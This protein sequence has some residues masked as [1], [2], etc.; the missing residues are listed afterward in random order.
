[1]PA[2]R[3]RT[4]RTSRWRRPRTRAARS[5]RRRCKAGAAERILDVPVGTA[6]G[7]YT[8]RA[9]FLGSA[10][11]VDTRKVKISGTFNPSIGVDDA[12]RVK[13]VALT[14]GDETVVILKVDA[15]FVVRGHAVRSRAAAR[16]RVRGQGDPRGVAQRTRRGRSSPAHGPLKLGSG[17]DAPDRLRPLP[18]RRSRRPRARRSRRGGPAKLGVFF[19]DNFDPTNQINHDRRGENDTLPGGNA[20]TITSS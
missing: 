14:A 20:R 8:A 16:S 10:G 3:P 6:L 13:A 4:A 5:R 11:V 12:P 19:D 2:S 7:G 1:M 9:G 15:I 17:R 18:R